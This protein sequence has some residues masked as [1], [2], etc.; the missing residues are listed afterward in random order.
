MSTDEE[1]AEP[2]VA[3]DEALFGKLQHLAECS[4]LREVA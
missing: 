1:A 2:P 4:S 3:A